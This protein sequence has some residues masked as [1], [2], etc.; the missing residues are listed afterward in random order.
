MTS[1]SHPLR[2]FLPADTERL[3]DLFAQSIEELTADDYD[4]EQRLAW[5][6]RAADG[7][8]FARRLSQGLTLVVERDGELLGF[9]SLKGNTEID[10]VYVHPY[11]VGEGIATALLDAL[12]RLAAA[13]GA[14]QLTADVSD[15]AHDVFQSRG[16]QPVRRNNI[17]IDDVWLANTTMTKTL[18]GTDDKDASAS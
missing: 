14:K 8:A 15:T 1:A 6:S 5:I 11:A 18:G 12:E 9:A 3:Q 10:M 2:P 4:A 7:A 16:Y 17:P 13:R